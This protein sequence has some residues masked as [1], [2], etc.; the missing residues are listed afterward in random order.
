MV[1]V[2]VGGLMKL[3]R[4]G[5]RAGVRPSVWHRALL[6]RGN[7][8]RAPPAAGLAPGPQKAGPREL[9]PGHLLW[10]TTGT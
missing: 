7:M 1:N 4:T 6:P 3:V 5:L 8:V 9:Q 2:V 10:S